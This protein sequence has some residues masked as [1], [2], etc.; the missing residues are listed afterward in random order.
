[1]NP[2]L[3]PQEDVDTLWEHLLAGDVGW[4]V[5]DHACCRSEQKFGEPADDVF[6]ARSGFGGTE[7]LLPGLV[8]RLPHTQVAALTSWQPAQRFGLLTKGAL[9][10]GYDAD[11][12]LVDPSR[13]W[14]V[15]AKDSASAQDYTPFEGFEMPATV[16]DTFVRGHHVLREGNVVGQP[17][18]RYLRRPV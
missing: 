13:S 17:T 14:T 11:F 1:V 9:A 5:S 7:Y 10:E 15:H 2:P 16:T 12:C 18:G 3:R 8:G 4:V 6:A